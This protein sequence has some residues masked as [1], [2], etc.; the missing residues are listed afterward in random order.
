MSTFSLS[1]L[2]SQNEESSHFMIKTFSFKTMTSTTPFANVIK[3]CVPR[4][5]SASD[6]SNNNNNVSLSA[7]KS[8]NNV[9]LS[10]CTHSASKAN[11]LPSLQEW[12]SRTL[13][14]EPEASKPSYSSSYAT[15]SKVVK[16]D[17][18]P[19]YY[20]IREGDFDLVWVNI[21]VFAVAHVVYFYG[22][23]NLS[24]IS[25]KTWFFASQVGNWA[26]FSIGCGAHRLWAHK[27]YD[28][29]IGLRIFY[30][31]GQTVAGQNC[32]YIWCRDHRVHHKFSDTNGDPHNTLRGYFFAHVGWLLRKK[33]PEL[34]IRSKTLDFSDLL[35]DP[36]VRIQKQ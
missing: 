21:C 16:E 7:E 19:F 32:L 28:A 25:W 20:F 34:K 1:S 15:K 36:V 17:T 35:N 4:K 23:L 27:S 9:P 18:T 2:S 14:I 3:Y 5:S 10:C 6:K 26:G 30:A 24:Q 33:H 12:R 29:S 8:N 31:L 13:S 22:L 11:E